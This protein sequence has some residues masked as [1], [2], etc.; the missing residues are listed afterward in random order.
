MRTSGC[1][2]RTNSCGAMPDPG[3][4]SRT[5]SPAS[6][7]VQ[8]P[9]GRPANRRAVV[10]PARTVRPDLPLSQ[11]ASLPAA[12]AGP[13]RPLEGQPQ[14]S[15]ANLSPFTSSPFRVI[16]LGRSCSKGSVLLQAG[17]GKSV[18]YPAGA[19][20]RSGGQKS[21]T[22][23]GRSTGTPPSDQLDEDA[24]GAP[25]GGG[26]VR[27]RHACL[28]MAWGLHFPWKGAASRWRDGRRSTASPLMHGP[29]S[30]STPFPATLS[31]PGC[32]RR[33]NALVLTCHP[34]L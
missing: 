17:S 26:P 22:R 6:L 2:R 7:V 31:V 34:S 15:E 5:T 3:S 1:P 20:T 8:R 28:R 30:R 13:V 23:R 9:G 21:L 25:S 14:G 16:A 18:V 10:P 29:A 4:P 11:D 19:V 12:G 32:C 33:R 27:R 24:P